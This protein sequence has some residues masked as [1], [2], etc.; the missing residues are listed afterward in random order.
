LVFSIS[1][2]IG[3]RKIRWI[4][5]TLRRIHDVKN[6]ADGHGTAVGG[7][8]RWS[9]DGVEAVRPQAPAAFFETGL[10]VIKGLH[11]GLVV[12]LQ[13]GLATGEEDERCSYDVDEHKGKKGDEQGAA[14]RG[15]S[16][17]C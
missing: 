12:V 6:V 3:G 13:G 17:L 5:L 9:R 8:D 2:G 7:E 1:V 10:G 15:M 4:D 16:L 11:G 14:A